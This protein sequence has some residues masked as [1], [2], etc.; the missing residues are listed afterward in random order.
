MREILKQRLS[1]GVKQAWGR[2]AEDSARSNRLDRELLELR[3][4]IPFHD[5]VIFFLDTPDEAREKE[6]QAELDELRQQRRDLNRAINEFVTETAGEF[7]LFAITARLEAWRTSFNLLLDD[8][9]LPRLGTKPA[10]RNQRREQLRAKVQADLASIRQ[11]FAEICLPGVD[12]H[13][14]VPRVTDRLEQPKLASDQEDGLPQRVA[15][16]LASLDFSAHASHLLWLEQE[17]AQGSPTPDLVENRNQ[18]LAE[19]HGLLVEAMGA[20][21][22]L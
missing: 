4:R 1:D 2:Q 6:V 18:A 11:A 13:V 7:P 10:A 22:A 12:L 19:V 8:P 17:F 21:P 16:A 3:Q 14:L 20:D 9:D 5:R 15:K